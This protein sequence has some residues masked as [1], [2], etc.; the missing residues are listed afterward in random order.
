MNQLY[1]AFGYIGL[2]IIATCAAL[3]VALFWSI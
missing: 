1:T 3:A 2:G